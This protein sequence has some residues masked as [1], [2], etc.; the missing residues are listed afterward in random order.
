MVESCRFSG[1]DRYRSDPAE[2]FGE[3]LLPGPAG[4]QM[5]RPTAGVRGQATGQ[6]EQAAADGA[7]GTDDTV[8]ESEQF[9]PAQQ[10]VRERCND[11]PGG[12]GVELSGGEV[13]ERLVFEVADD[14]LDDSVLAVLGLD[15]RDLLVAVGRE[16]VVLPGREQLFL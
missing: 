9:G 4:G 12:V 1:G 13:L 8:G 11:C 10:V 6:G 2:R 16:R 7:R 3:V 5:Q 15:E 14:G